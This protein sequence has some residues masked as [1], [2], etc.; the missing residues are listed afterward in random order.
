MIRM[1]KVKRLLSIAIFTVCFGIYSAGPG[2][3]P[4]YGNSAPSYWDAFPYSE[5]LSVDKDSP[6]TV[7]H[8]RLTF[9]FSKTG[10]YDDRDTRSPVGRVTAEYQMTNPSD[11]TLAVQMAFPFAASFYNL[12]ISDISVSADG[13]AVP[14]EIYVDPDEIY[15]YGDSDTGFTYDDRAIGN[16]TKQE[17]VMPVF[18]LNEEAKLYRFDLSGSRESRLDLEISFDADPGQ[19]LLIGNGFD[20]ASYTDQGIGTLSIRIR[21][22]AEAEILVLGKDT[23]LK[24]EVLTYEGAPADPEGYQLEIRQDSADPKQYLLAAIQKEIGTETAAAI[25]DTQLL[26]LCLR[27]VWEESQRSGYA[28]LFQVFSRIHSDRIFTLVYQAEFL[29]KSTKNI[30]VG[31]LTEGGMDRRETVSPKYTYTYLLSPARNW[32]DFGSL[33]VEIITPEEAP[34]VIESSLP[35]ARDGENLY[36]AGFDGLPE[37]ELTFTLYKNKNI[38]LIDQAEKTIYSASYLIFFLGSVLWPVIAVILA[39]IVIKILISVIRRKRSR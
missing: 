21:E 2:A 17:W 38:T 12:S 9:D 8:E 28:A 39:F 13:S 22:K 15:T 16:I 33:D 10:D 27:E 19:T 31:Y 34:Y 35:F 26:N 4:I 29:P 18:D 1:K 37:A 14:F 32:A 5:V 24:Y 23:E 6:V 36:S 11:D 3:M 30:R 7:D 20:G 25:S